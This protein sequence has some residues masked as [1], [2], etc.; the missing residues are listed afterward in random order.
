MLFGGNVRAS[1]KMQA[2]AELDEI[3]IQA[4]GG[5]IRLAQVVLVGNGFEDQHITFEADSSITIGVP[6]PDGKVPRSSIRG[7]MGHS[8][9]ASPLI[10]QATGAIQIQELKARLLSAITLETSGTEIDFLES[11]VLG[12]PFP[13]MPVTLTAG[14]GSTCDL[15]DSDFDNVGLTTNCD[16][17]V[18]P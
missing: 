3:L 6:G 11:R 4:S 12:F 5:E 8:G 14:P 7:G 17:V 2:E 18:G 15:S 13:A 9:P 10:F 16:T 1:G